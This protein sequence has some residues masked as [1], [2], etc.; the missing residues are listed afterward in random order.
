[1]QVYEVFV[2]SED[3]ASFLI[4]SDSITNA[5]QAARRF[6]FIPIRAMLSTT[7]LPGMPTTRIV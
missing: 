5:I 3:F 2:D 7:M 4:A 6:G 1:M